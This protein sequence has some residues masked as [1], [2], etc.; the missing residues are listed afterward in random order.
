[1]KF[2]LQQIVKYCFYKYWLRTPKR[3]IGYVYKKIFNTKL[4]WKNPISLNEKINWLK[5]YGDTSK[6]SQLA[7]KYLVRSYVESKGLS[8]ILIPLYGNWSDVNDIDFDKLPNSFV[9]KTNHGCGGVYIVKDKMK[10]NLEQIRRELNISVNQ[11]YGF[12]QG[13]PHYL[14]IK[15]QIIAEALLENENCN[16]VSMIDYKVWCFNGKPYCIFICYNRTASGLY[17]ECYDLNWNYRREWLRETTNI[18]IG[19]G[20]IPRPENL[21]YILNCAEILAESFPQVRVDLYS[22]KDRVY[23]GEMTFTSLGGF[24]EYFTDQAL[25]DMGKL[26]QL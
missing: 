11:R 10:S 20:I 6:W 25:N 12:Y 4:N 13:E 23:F 26:I 5:V 1:M 14:Q 24:M 16:S 9:L 7:D 21:Q 22:V 19:E 3:I 8:N 2:Y 15:P 18:I 17:I